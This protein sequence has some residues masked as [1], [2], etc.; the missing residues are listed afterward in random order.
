[1]HSI[2]AQAGN[3]R[4]FQQEATLAWVSSPNTLLSFTAEQHSIQ[5]RNYFFADLKF[6]F[7]PKGSSQDFEISAVNL[8]NQASF[9]TVFLSEYMYQE[10]AFELR[11]R[12]FLLRGS[13]RL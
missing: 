1:M 4:Q 12:Q 10:S 2:R 13:F 7:T 5:S 6:R 8:F 11:P 9:K 3:L